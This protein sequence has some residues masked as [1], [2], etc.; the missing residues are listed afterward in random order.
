MVNG[1]LSCDRCGRCCSYVIPVN[2]LDIHRIAAHLNVNPQEV[3]ETYVTYKGKDPFLTLAKSDQGRCAFLTEDNLCRIHPVKPWTCRV[4]MCTRTTGTAEALSWAGSHDGKDVRTDLWEMTVA[5]RQTEQY[6]QK[7]GA[8][9]HEPD[10]CAAVTAILSGLDLKETQ[11]IRFVTTRDGDTQAILYDCSQCKERPMCCKEAPVT[12]DDVVRLSGQ[13][14]LSVDAFFARHVGPEPST[15]AQGLLALKA[16]NENRCPFRRA[17]SNS[18]EIEHIRPMQCRFVP[19]PLLV[20]ETET[21]ERF[22]LGAGTVEEQFRHQC[23]TAVTRR[24][25]AQYGAAYRPQGV[26]QML[27]VLDRLASDQTQ[28]ACFC[29][30]LAPYRRI[31]APFPIVN[32]RDPTPLPTHT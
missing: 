7:H 24:Y 3:L 12:L 9:W 28:F 4:Y 23:A 31:D 19:C 26:E 22:F 6:V 10:Y 14:N 25:V 2:L 8:T 30:E 29:E 15:L 32:Q 11:R 20:G 16:P 13:L 5:R 18:C 21:A 27:H 17:A 1:T